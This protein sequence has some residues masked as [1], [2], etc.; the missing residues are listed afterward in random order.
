MRDQ[1]RSL[2]LAKLYDNRGFGK[3]KRKQELMHSA[4]G[5]VNQYNHLET[6]LVIPYW[7]KIPLVYDPVIPLLRI[8]I[9]AQRDMYNRVYCKIVLMKN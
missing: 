1:F 6:Y 5:N 7:L 3:S 8:Y 2:R 9:W 4:N